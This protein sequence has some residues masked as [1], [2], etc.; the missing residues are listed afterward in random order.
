MEVMRLV[1]TIHFNN[2][3][4]KVA[5][6]K[7]PWL[8]SRHDETD[9]LAYLIPSNEKTAKQIDDQIYHDHL[10]NEYYR[11][12]VNDGRAGYINKKAFV[13]VS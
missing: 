5:L 3:L 2:K 11:V 10:D 4:K 9:V 13:E 6:R 1:K 7:R 12:I 8:P